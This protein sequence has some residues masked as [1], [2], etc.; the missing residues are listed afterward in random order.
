M[1]V[2]RK[3]II[4]QDEK[5]GDYIVVAKC[6]FHKE[7]AYDKSKVKSGGEWTLDM[8]NKTFTLFGSSHDFGKA[9]FEDIANCVKNKRVFS[10]FTQHRCLTDEFKFKYKDDRGNIFNLK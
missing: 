5:E 2:F 3:F 7:L 4:E 9:E 6:T 1:D 8:V 10:S